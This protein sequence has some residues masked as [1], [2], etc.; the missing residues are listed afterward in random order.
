MR[1][2]PAKKRA[3]GRIGPQLKKKQQSQR[4]S[5]EKQKPAKAL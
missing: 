4:V 5:L 2:N 3:R 1:E